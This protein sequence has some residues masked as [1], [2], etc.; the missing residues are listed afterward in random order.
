MNKVYLGII[1]ILAC[2]C[3]SAGQTRTTTKQGPLAEAPRDDRRVTLASGTSMSAELQKTLDAGN[4]RVGDQISLKT[5]QSIK[6]N[7]EVVVPKGSTLI[8]RVTEVQ[9]RTKENAQSRIGVVFE[10]IQGKQVSLPLSATIVSITNVAAGASANDSLLTDVAGSSQTTASTAR[11]GGGGGGLLG[12]VT[13]T[14]GGLVGATTQT[15]G[16]VTNTAGQTLGSTA[17]A[18]GSGL[19]GV[20]ISTSASGS[21]HSSTTLSSANKNL[22]VEKGATFHIRVAN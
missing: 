2:V 1:T 8:G 6:Q 7:G 10:R 4:A 3:I 14:A 20:Q 22:R 16:S 18:V 15:V 13:N 17:G 19:S 9:R 5:T 11:I 21:A 12:G